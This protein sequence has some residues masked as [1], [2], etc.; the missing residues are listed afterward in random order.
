MTVSRRHEADEL[1][2]KETHMRRR[3]AMLN[4]VKRIIN[5]ISF[6][7]ET[8]NVPTMEAIFDC[9][10]EPPT[11]EETLAH[12]VFVEDYAKED[13]RPVMGFVDESTECYH[14]G[15]TCSRNHV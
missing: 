12:G 3:N 1:A 14:E 5:T 11:H 15:C 8:I 2:I 10:I 13:T 6:A 7:D 4:L 9:S